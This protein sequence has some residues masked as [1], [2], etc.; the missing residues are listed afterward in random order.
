MTTE[1]YK[2][3][4]PK[5]L[6]SLVGN[7]GTV[8][9]LKNMLKRKSLPHTLLFHGPSGC[10]KTTLARILRRELKCSK[11]DWQEV[12]VSS[13]RGIDS[14]RDIMRNMSLSPTG[15]PVRIWHLDE[16]HQWTKDAQHSALKM[17][18]DTPSHVYFFL[19]TTDPGKLLKTIRTRCCDMPLTLLNEKE[20]TTLTAR[21]ARKESIELSDDTMSELVEISAGSARV[22][23]VLLD[24]V[25][26]LPDSERVKAMKQKSE[27]EREAIDLC[28]SLIKKESWNKVTKILRNLKGDPE[29][30]RWAVIGYARSVLIKK[31]DHNAYNVIVAFENNFYDSKQAG[32]VRACYE[33]VF[34][35]G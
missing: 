14:V 19:S 12:N 21:V 29:G 33:A 18:E 32:L 25:A 9:T 2:K 16:V 7:E 17:L 30:V 3:H 11:L 5:K 1:L 31:K 20:L 15:G 23:L 26:N 22:A 4:R 6:K 27:L 28:R 34:G 35:D 10:G 8:A 13:N 24:K